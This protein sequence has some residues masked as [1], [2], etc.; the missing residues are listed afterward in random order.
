MCMLPLK[1]QNVLLTDDI[2]PEH[3]NLPLFKSG[4]RLFRLGPE[5]PRN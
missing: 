4:R 2:L 3:T 5:N 1:K